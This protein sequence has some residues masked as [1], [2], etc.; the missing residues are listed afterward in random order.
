[1]DAIPFYLMPLAIVCI[2][3]SIFL[4]KKMFQRDS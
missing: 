1:M 2:V 4:V 3:I